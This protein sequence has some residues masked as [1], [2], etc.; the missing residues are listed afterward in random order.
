MALVLVLP[1][2]DDTPSAPSA[3]VVAPPAAK[4]RNADKSDKADKRTSAAAAPAPAKK[5]EVA[6]E[7]NT[8]EVSRIEKRLTATDA[9]ASTAASVARLVELWTGTPPDKNELDADTLDMEMIGSRRSLSYLGARLSPELLASVDL[10]AIVE[11]RVGADGETR[12]VVIERASA[13]MVTLHLEKPLSVSRPDLRAHV[14]GSGSPVLEGRRG[15]SANVQG[16]RIRAGRHTHAGLAHRARRPARATE[17]GLRRGHRQ[18]GPDAPDLLWN[19]RGRQS[20]R[21]H[22]NH[23]LQCGGAL[24]SPR[25]LERAFEDTREDG[26]MSSIL[27]ALLKASERRSARS[28]TPSTVEPAPAPAAVATPPALP[29]PPKA[30]APR[31]LP[32][33]PQAAVPS[34]H[35]AGTTAVTRSRLARVPDDG[36]GRRRASVARDRAAGCASA[37]TRRARRAYLPAAATARRIPRRRGALVPADRRRRA[38]DDAS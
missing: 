31:P 28:T 23:P 7:V 30:A 20:R 38:H 15:V 8:A 16:R 19:S 22:P 33:L 34:T 3:A 26:V 2:R 24:P 27:D 25:S 6:A 17:R 21:T 14:D 29:E 11:L 12:Y 35:R 9:F 32:D 18:R 5:K 1:M 36:R 10:P 37:V 4:A 13:N